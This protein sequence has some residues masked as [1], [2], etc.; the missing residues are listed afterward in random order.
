[1]TEDRVEECLLQVQTRILETLDA[2]RAQSTHQQYGMSNSFAADL[3]THGTQET[4]HLMSTQA[5]CCT[6]YSTLEC[7]CLKQGMARVSLTGPRPQPACVQSSDHMLQWD[8]Q[9]LP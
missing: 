9:R 6:D 5:A 7:L 2:P 8:Q 3:H 4:I 1:M